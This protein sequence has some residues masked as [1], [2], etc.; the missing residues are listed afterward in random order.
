MKK[1]CYLLVLFIVCACN[2]TTDVV[3]S[4]VYNKKLYLSEVESLLP[5]GLTAVDSAQTADRIIEEWLKQ[6][7]LL[8]EAN[9][10]LSEKEKN[11]DKE[12]AQYQKNLLIQ[13]YCQKITSD[14]SQFF[15]S[16]EEVKQ[17][18][19]HFG[20][21]GAEEQTIVKLSYIKLSRKSKVKRE[22]T[23]LLFDKDN[24][25]VN[26]RKLEEL[27]AD[28]L[29]YF[30][31]DNTWIYLNEIE[32]TLP[33]DLKNEKFSANSPKNIEKCDDRFCYLIV[34]LDQRKRTIPIAT[35]ENLESIRAM[36]IQQKKTDF[37]NRK[38]EELYLQAVE[39]EKILK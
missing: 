18:M 29:E 22:I 27:C 9:K 28:S 8:H 20:L 26:K 13:A 34:L 11:F 19:T 37:L 32:Y 17:Y 38:I 21:A 16:D 23:E 6:Q 39:S 3:V 4:E 12:I 36:L 33:V 1:Y 24:R 31:D 7:I 14:T 25:K 5:S 30:L 2:R 10:V 15:I 35:A